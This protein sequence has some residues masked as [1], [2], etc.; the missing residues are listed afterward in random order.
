MDRRRKLFYSTLASVVLS[1]MCYLLVLAVSNDNQ[2]SFDLSADQRFSFSPQTEK[3]VTGLDFPVKVYVFADPGGDRSRIEDLLERYRRLNGKN[4]SYEMVDLELK[5]NLA[6]DLEVRAY[7]TGV[8]E[9]VEKGK[10]KDGK[11]RRERVMVFDEASITNALLKLSITETKKVGFLTGH[12]EREMVGSEKA[13]VSALAVALGTEGFT[14]EAIKLGESKALP[15]DLAILVIAGPTNPLLEGEK[16]LIDDYLKKGGKLLFLADVF[17]PAPYV[18]WLKGYGFILQDS[19]LIDKKSALAGADPVFIFGVTNPPEHPITRGFKAYILEIQARPVDVGTAEPIIESGGRPELQSLIRSDENTMAVP[20]ADVLGK[21]AVSVTTNTETTA[22][23]SLAVAG[24]YPRSSSAPP[25]PTPSATPGQAP[26][27]VEISSRIVVV[28]NVDAFSNTSLPQA[29]NRDF[30][31]NTI[32]WLGQTENQITV[33]TKDPKSQPLVLEKQ[34]E[35]WLTF[36]FGLLLPFL[37]M[38]TG[39]LISQGRRRGTKE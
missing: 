8:L 38:L 34:Q 5:P 2:K 30:I 33:R 14:T 37:C 3:V 6:K 20:L 13:S 32:N 27:S 4:F 35:R 23:Q 7:G 22:A 28:G 36:L 39:L 25:S 12:G 1:L 31:L 10:A 21:G 24:L 15:E 18:E 19:M 9:R 11:P 17:T 29:A 16:K 26:P